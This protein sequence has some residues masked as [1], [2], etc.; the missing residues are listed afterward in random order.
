MTITVGPPTTLV[1]TRP[2]TIT[3]VTTELYST[4]SGE[5]LSPSSTVDGPYYPVPTRTRCPHTNDAFACGNDDGGDTDD[6]A[7]EVWLR[8]GVS[9]EMMRQQELAVDDE[10]SHSSD[11]KANFMEGIEAA[12]SSG[13]ALTV[14][15]RGSG[16]LS[17]LVLVAATVL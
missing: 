11:E 6:N 12:L 2:I 5:T 3:T 7:V 4:I 8:S 1:T 17:V 16:L 9:A 14:T 13:G 15:V 10:G